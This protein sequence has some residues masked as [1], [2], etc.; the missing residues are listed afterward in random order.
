MSDTKLLLDIAELEADRDKVRLFGQEYE[1]NRIDDLSPREHVRIDIGRAAVTEYL[2]LPASKRTEELADEMDGKLNVLVRTAVR[3][4]ADDEV[5][6][7]PFSHR[8]QILAVFLAS[9]GLIPERETGAKVARSRST[10]GK[11]SRGS[12]RATAETPSAG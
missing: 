9:N 5:A 2:N 7:I 8:L 11:S 4:L 6:R 1:L 3:G 10:G 12:R